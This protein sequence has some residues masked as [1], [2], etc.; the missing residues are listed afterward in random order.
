M[1]RRADSVLNPK[2]QASD[3]YSHGVNQEFSIFIQTWFGLLNNF[4]LTNS[5]DL[6]NRKNIIV[7]RLGFVSIPKFKQQ[8]IPFFKLLPLNSDIIFKHDF[9][10]FA[11]T[12]IKALLFH[13]M[14]GNQYHRYLVI[15]NYELYNYLT[16][17]RWM[18]IFSETK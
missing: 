18:N 13:K 4:L 6:F 11:T 9:T 8:P 17:H 12:K 1:L 14:N 7:G 2:L 10:P 5:Y 16:W 3:T 15:K